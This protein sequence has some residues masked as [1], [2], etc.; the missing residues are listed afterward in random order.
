MTKEEETKKIS[1][2]NVESVTK[3]LTQEKIKGKDY[4]F[5]F[6]IGEII[7]K[8]IEALKVLNKKTLPVTYSAK[9]YQ[10]NLFI[11][12]I[13]QRVSSKEVHNLQNLVR[14]F[15]VLKKSIF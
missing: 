15:F 10:V 6:R 1:T 5:N 11:L 2:I 3:E 12:L 9:F 4:D 8:N 14:N 13:L 7:D